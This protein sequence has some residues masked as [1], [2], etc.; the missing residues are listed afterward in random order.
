MTTEQFSIRQARQ[1]STSTSSFL[2]WTHTRYY[3][4][5]WHGVYLV[6]LTSL[7]RCSNSQ[8]WLSRLWC[9]SFPQNLVYYRLPCFRTDSGSI[10]KRVIQEMFTWI[11]LFPY[12]ASRSIRRSHSNLPWTVA[13]IFVTFSLLK[14]HRY[15]SSQYP[16]PSR[17]E[18]AF[19]DKKDSWFTF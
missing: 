8:Y 2:R 17:S 15:L 3:N 13:L 12:L 19:F 1:L 10:S 7:R 6:R 5:A 16:L 4:Y 11:Q 14:P 9:S 18:P